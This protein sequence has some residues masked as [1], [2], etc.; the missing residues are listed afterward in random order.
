YFDFLP[1]IEGLEGVDGVPV[2]LKVSVVVVVVCII[3]GDVE[4]GVE[5][6]VETEFV[7]DFFLGA[8]VAD[9]F[10]GVGVVPPGKADF[11]GGTVVPIVVWWIGW[12]KNWELNYGFQGHFW[13]GFRLNME[14]EIGACAV[15]SD[16]SSMRPPESLV[17]G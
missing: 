10:L 13:E 11:G 6:F 4:G 2:D 3:V 5:A 15:K 14:I 8:F 17:C 16:S 12:S 1:G 9:E 7:F